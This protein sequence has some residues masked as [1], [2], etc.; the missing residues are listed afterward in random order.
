[1][2]SEHRPDFADGLAVQRTLAAIEK[3]HE[4]GEWIDVAD[5]E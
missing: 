2:G 3:S 5:V 4:R 1:V